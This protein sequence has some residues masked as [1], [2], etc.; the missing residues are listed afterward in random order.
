MA[1]EFNI[2]ARRIRAA[3]TD[4]P[5]EEVQAGLNDLAFQTTIALNSLAGGGGTIPSGNI[6]Y[7]QGSAGAVTRT[8]TS[9]LQDVISLK[10]FGAK[11]D[12]VTDDTTAVQNFFNALGTNVSGYIPFGTYLFTAALSIPVNFSS[13]IGTGKYSS[14]FVYGGV[15]TTANLFSIVGAAATNI[16]ASAVL[17]GFGVRSNT[18]MTAG[19]ALFIKWAGHIT[20]F[21]VAFGAQYDAAH[22]LWNGIEYF[23]TDFQLLDD[24]DIQVQNECIRASG[25]GAG[26]PGPQFDIWVGKGKACLSA[27]GL[28]IGGGIDNVYFDRMIVTFNGTNVLIDNAIQNFKNQEVGFGPQC[29]IDQAQTGDNIRIND[30]LANQTNYGQIMIQGPVTGSKV[31]HGI[32]ILNWPNCFVNVASPYIDNNALNGIFIQDASAQVLLSSDTNISNNGNFGISAAFANTPVVAPCTFSGNA[33]GALNAN[34]LN[35]F[36]VTSGRFSGLSANLTGNVNAAAALLTAQSTITTSGSTRSLQITDT[37][38][39]G[40][41][42]QLVGNGGATPSKFIRANGGSFQVVNDAYG[43]VILSLNDAGNLVVPN[44][45]NTPIG[46]TTPSTGAFTTLSATSTVSGAG[47]TARFSSPGPIGNTAAST[48]AFT[49]LSSTGTFTPSSTN[50]IVGT[51]TNDNANAGSV[52]EFVSNSATGV[53]LTSNTPANITSISLTAGDWDVVGNI[54]FTAAA[55]T[56]PSNFFSGVS[57]TSAT[58]PTFASGNLNQISNSAF[59][60]NSANSFIAPTQ[61]FS[62]STTTT[63]FLVGQSIFTTSTMTAGGLIRAR[64]VR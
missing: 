38:A 17:S 26:N 16:K 9:K 11:G 34:V 3:G 61:R 51:T 56:V 46:A 39:S 30:N 7:S 54:A 47:F 62:L 10:D 55:T 1:D 5:P 32:N 36:A 15:S 4:V 52:G 23:S 14:V 22:N 28:H 60:A 59:P 31:G 19:D 24:F 2:V 33:S 18:V 21:N 48:G 20:T 64:R 57:S 37:G 58:L 27:V 44:I 35:N 63:I 6:T 45:N 12:G 41:N 8:L 49:T 29:V 43:A 13:L 40:A 25:G 42:L 53:S 50:G